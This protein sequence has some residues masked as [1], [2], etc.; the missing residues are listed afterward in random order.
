MD[1]A[2]QQVAFLAR[3]VVS[4]DPQQ[5]EGALSALASSRRTVAPLGWALGTI[6]LLFQGLRTIVV[7]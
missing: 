3:A 7:N 4:S 2:R 1:R 6:I 5:V